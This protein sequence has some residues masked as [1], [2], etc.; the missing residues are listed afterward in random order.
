MV[1]KEA[2]KEKEKS[3]VTAVFIAQFIHCW[4]RQVKWNGGFFINLYLLIYFIYIFS[5]LTAVVSV[6]QS[7]SSPNSFCI[8]FILNIFTKVTCYKGKW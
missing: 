5:R 2:E 4:W 7:V 3:S 1:Q 8:L 6:V